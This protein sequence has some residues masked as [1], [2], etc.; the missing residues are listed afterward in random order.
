MDTLT[1]PENLL[2]QADKTLKNW[3]I[4]TY[5]PVGTV[6]R[7]GFTVAPGQGEQ[8]GSLGPNVSKEFSKDV[9]WQSMNERME[10]RLFGTLLRLHKEESKVGELFVAQ[11]PSESDPQ[12][13]ILGI[14]GFQT[15]TPRDGRGAKQFVISLQIPHEIS[16]DVLS[17]IKAQPEFADS[18]IKKLFPTLDA[19]VGDYNNGLRRY[20]ADTVRIIDMQRFKELHPDNKDLIRFSSIQDILNETP[21]LKLAQPIGEWD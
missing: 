11:W 5:L 16:S 21:A 13:S 6:I 4:N 15:D 19:K 3:C 9:S 10:P 12:Y 17:Q 18:L 8:W 7:N 20:K 2:D 1:N 14:G